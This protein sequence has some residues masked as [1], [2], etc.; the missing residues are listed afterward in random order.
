MRQFHISN[1][2]VRN[3]ERTVHLSSAHNNRA[4]NGLFWW[5]RK[6]RYMYTCILKLHKARYTVLWLIQLEIIIA[7][8]VNQFYLSSSSASHSIFFTVHEI[9]FCCNWLQNSSFSIFLIF[10]FF[11]CFIIEHPL[12]DFLLSNYSRYLKNTHAKILQLGFSQWALIKP[13][14]FFKVVFIHYISGFYIC[15]NLSFWL[16]FATLSRI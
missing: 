13:I 8:P 7:P 3:A 12:F 14:R 4:E 1:L 10:F 15:I 9:T 11:S 2:F 6:R 16:D 5:H